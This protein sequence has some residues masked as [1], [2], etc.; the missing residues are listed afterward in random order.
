MN[1][2]LS[3]DMY[4]YYPSIMYITHVS[5]MVSMKSAVHYLLIIYTFLVCLKTSCW[6]ILQFTWKLYIINLIR[7]IYST[8]NLNKNREKS[9]VDAWR[10]IDNNL[11]IHPLKLFPHTRTHKFNMSLFLLK[12]CLIRT[13][14]VP[15]YLYT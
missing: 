14:S 13:I 1:V 10:L 8:R 11:C 9:I 7:Q 6:I 3:T 2:K 12:C 5:C 15:C 4:N